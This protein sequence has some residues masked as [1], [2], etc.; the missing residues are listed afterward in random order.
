[1]SDY[2][3]PI[4]QDGKKCVLFVPH[5]FRELLGFLLNGRKQRPMGLK[6]FARFSAKSL[7]NSRPK[8]K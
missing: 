8:K 2:L 5:F 3:A 1:V 7:R 4:Y 6:Q